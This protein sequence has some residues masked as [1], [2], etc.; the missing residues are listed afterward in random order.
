MQSW[1]I[2]CP[3]NSFDDGR[4]TSEEIDGM[5]LKGYFLPG[6]KLESN[7]VLYEVVGKMYHHQR[8]IRARK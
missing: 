3:E 8:K 1:K 5:L 6:T 2:Y 7:G 4:F